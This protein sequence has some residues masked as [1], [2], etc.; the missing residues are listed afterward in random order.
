MDVTP[1]VGPFV[2]DAPEDRHAERVVAMML[3]CLDDF[4]ATGDLRQGAATL[5]C[6]PAVLH[7]VAQSMALRNVAIDFAKQGFK[8]SKP[9]T[10]GFHPSFM[11][12]FNNHNS[13]DNRN[14]VS[15]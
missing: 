15:P 14:H 3:T 4:A 7:L 12:S 6:L 8:T 2:G 1:S 10:Y 5:P 13:H 11:K 9:I